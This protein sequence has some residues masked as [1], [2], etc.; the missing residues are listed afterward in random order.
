MKTECQEKRRE[1][2]PGVRQIPRGKNGVEQKDGRKR[3]DRKEQNNKMEP[4]NPNP[5]GSIPH[6]VRGSAARTGICRKVRNL[7]GI[8]ILQVRT[9]IPGWSSP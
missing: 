1:T 7:P 9:V 4:G 5:C 6:R 2:H 8:P 3:K